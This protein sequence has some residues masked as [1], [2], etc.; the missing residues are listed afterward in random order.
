MHKKV[1]FCRPDYTDTFTLH[2]WALL[3][4]KSTFPNSPLAGD[5][6]TNTSSAPA[7]AY[8]EF[9]LSLAKTFSGLN[10]GMP[11]PSKN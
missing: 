6:D 3:A 2:Y 5:F 9:G 1:C 10:G 7:R 4:D 8:L 11:I